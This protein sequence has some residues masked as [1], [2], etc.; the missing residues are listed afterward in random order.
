MTQTVNPTATQ[1]GRGSKRI[2]AWR[3]GAKVAA[4]P[5]QHALA[6]ELLRAVPAP[7]QY[8]LD[9]SCWEQIANPNHYHL[10]GNEAANGM[11]PARPT[12]NSA[13]VRPH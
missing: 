1:L 3:H 7:R 2:A 9:V 10:T 6:E 11:P 12:R 8:E 13:T 5:V 4:G